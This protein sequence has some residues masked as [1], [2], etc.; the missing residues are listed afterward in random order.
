MNKC[1]LQLCPECK[2]FEI[3]DTLGTSPKRI[4]NKWRVELGL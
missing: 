1:L 4:S 2:D 3:K